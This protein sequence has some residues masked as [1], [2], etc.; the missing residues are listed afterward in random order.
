MDNTGF[1]EI[2]RRL[3][4][5]HAQKMREAAQLGAEYKAETPEVQ[6]EPIPQPSSLVEKI[7]GKLVRP[8]GQQDAEDAI[9]LQ[10]IKQLMQQQR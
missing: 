5:E 8:L 10:R 1:D 2:N 4:L 9:R 6:P 3:A 7:K